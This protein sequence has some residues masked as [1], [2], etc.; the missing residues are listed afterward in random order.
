MNRVMVSIESGLKEPAWFNNVEK[1][2]LF[3]ME[4]LS[5]DGQEISVMFCSD[6]NIQS[7]N[8]TYRGIDSPTDVLSFEAR[9]EYSDEEGT[10]LAM[11][12]II[13]SLDTLPKN[14][15]YFEVDENSELK[16]LLLHGLLHL[17]GY[18]HGEEHIEKNKTPECEML[19]LQEELL[20][21]IKDYI[22]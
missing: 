10:W 5:F 7:L 12:D 4:K 8:A 15:A 14:A 13:I 6:E 22:I 2:I 16:R 19:V 20:A 18:D 1:Y 3:L 21:E 9:D 11:G 17:N